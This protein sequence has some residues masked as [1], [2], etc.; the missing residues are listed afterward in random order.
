[1][2][3]TVVQHLGWWLILRADP[4]RNLEWAGFGLDPQLA[5]LTA[6]SLTTGRVDERRARIT[7]RKTREEAAAD[8]LAASRL[9]VNR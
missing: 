6:Q 5:M 8:A 1:M 4:D 7:W 3:Y 2:R 9:V